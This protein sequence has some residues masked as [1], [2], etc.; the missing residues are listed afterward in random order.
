MTDKE[1]N[2][3]DLYEEWKEMQIEEKENEHKSGLEVKE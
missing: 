1:V 3:D 2:W